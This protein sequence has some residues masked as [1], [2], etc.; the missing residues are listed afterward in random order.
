MGM[1]WYLTMGGFM[2]N[3]PSHTPDQDGWCQNPGCD[4]NV[5][6]ARST[7]PCPVNFGG[8]KAGTIQEQEDMLAGNTPSDNPQCLCA[9]HDNK[10]NK[11]YDHDIACCGNMNGVVSNPQRSELYQRIVYLID[12]GFRPLMEKLNQADS[13]STLELYA[14]IAKGIIIDISARDAQLK[15]RLVAELAKYTSKHDQPYVTWCRDFLDANFKEI[16]ESDE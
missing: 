9:R 6:N 11:P 4:W 1:D 13:Q 8:R 3:T 10:L 15:E 14:L 7:P 5:W 2:N 12:T 16:G